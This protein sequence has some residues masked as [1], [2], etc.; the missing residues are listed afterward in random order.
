MSDTGRLT[1]TI[2]L[3]MQR[4][5][6]GQPTA[7]QIAAE[8]AQ[9]T[10]IDLA[11]T[12]M[13]AEQS[14]IGGDAAAALVTE[15]ER[16]RRTRFAELAATLMPRGLYLAY[17]QHLVAAL[18]ADVGGV[19]HTGRSRN[20]MKAT[21]TLMRLRDWLAS[22]MEEAT[23]LAAVL[24]AR[25]RAHS[26]VVMPVHTH[27]QAA[28]PITYGYYLT[29]V[30]AALL[31]EIE[32]VRDAARGLERCPMGAGAVA[33]TDL[34]L[35]PARVAELLGFREAPLH[36]LD[37]IASRDV[38]LRLLANATGTAVLLSRLGTDLQLWSTEEFGFLR[39]PD[40]LVGSSSA[41]PQKRNAFLLEHV[42]AAAAA[43]SGSWIA[44][45][46]AMKGTPF[47]NSIEVGTEAVGSAWRG[48]DATVDALLMCQSLVSG[49][50]PCPERM[51]ERARDGYTTAT[52]VA[53]DLVRRGVPFRSAHHQVGTAIR[54]ALAG[55][56]DASWW[57]P[58][59]ADPVAAVRRADVGGGPGAW[60]AAFADVHARL[61]AARE[62]QAAER[63]R[64]SAA[65]ER[66]S[67]AV[68]AVRAG[69][70]TRPAPIEVA[71]VAS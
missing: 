1:A 18:G 27:F 10:L 7:D 41:M 38:V 36:A 28:M 46:T 16:L 4:L 17:E 45:V 2:G 52:A 47:T 19:L 8:L 55:D 67:S 33:G 54:R 34:P 23:R 70:P 49:G 25:S 57:D 42:T 9:T 3:R 30:A 11:H 44:A 5:L 29:G 6:Y 22:F 66:L 26:H 64:L 51:V 21:A 40:R 62:W 58:V 63:A 24:L 14:L 20:D 31:R 59:V 68:A 56:R 50:R 12:V 39:F 32:G 43:T 61:C 35:A 48:L 53:N 37:A 65:R 60:P 13:L 71:G 15:I 69:G